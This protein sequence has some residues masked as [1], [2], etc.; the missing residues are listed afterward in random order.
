MLVFA[1]VH[2]SF[3]EQSYKGR[4]LLPLSKLHAV[5]LGAQTEFLT[6]IFLVRTSE[7]SFIFTSFVKYGL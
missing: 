1:E 2:S 3:A 6:T 7:D 5:D 4:N